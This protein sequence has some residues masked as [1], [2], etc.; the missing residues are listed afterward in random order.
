MSAS[1]VRPFSTVDKIS[2]NNPILAAIVGGFLLLF[3]MPPFNVGIFIFLAFVPVLIALDEKSSKHWFLAG[4]IIGWLWQSYLPLGLAGWEWKLAIL[5]WA[6]AGPFMGFTLVI[7]HFFQHKLTPQLRWLA[8]PFAW[9]IITSFTT[10]FM[11]SPWSFAPSL[12]LNFKA[13]LIIG[14]YV[15]NL[16]LEWIILAV[17]SLLAGGYLYGWSRRNLPITFALLL[18]IASTVLISPPKVI[19]TVPVYGLQTAISHTDFATSGWS[20][21]TRKKIEH[22]VD[23]LTRT[24]LQEPVGIV[25]QPEGGNNLNN[26]RLLRRRDIISDLLENNESHLLLTGIDIDPNGTKLNIVS[27]VSRSGFHS[28]SGKQMTVPFAEKKLGKGENTVFHTPMATVGMAICF[29][30]LF[31]HHINNL[32]KN[33]AEFIATITDDSSFGTSTLAQVHL[34][35]AIQRSITVAKS[36]VFLNNNG[37][38]AAVDSHGNILDIDWMGSEAQVYSWKIPINKKV[39]LAQKGGEIFFLGVIIGF[40]CLLLLIGV[41]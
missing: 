37:L 28:S 7:T 16:G 33:G 19:N 36:L 32:A 9:L 23:R 14:Q 39:T 15:G 21:S 22:K 26:L 8:L 6:L 17:S 30:A 2:S 20:L 10:Y 5:P 12:A 29:E 34:A 24:A 3:S 1:I 31:G 40:T 25:L 27:H 35:Y 41:F 11:V 38:S 18:L 4:C 13:P